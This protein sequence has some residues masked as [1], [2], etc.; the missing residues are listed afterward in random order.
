[1]YKCPSCDSVAVENYYTNQRQCVQCGYSGP[2]AEFSVEDDPV[3]HPSHYTFS[4]YE[5]IDVISAWDLNFNLG[6]VVKYIARCDHKDNK[7]QDLEKA[8]YYLRH[9][10]AKEELHMGDPSLSYGIAQVITEWGLNFNLGSV[11]QFV[12]ESTMCNAKEHIMVELRRAENSLT[13]EIEHLKQD[14]D[15]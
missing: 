5:V 7:I 3:A 8:L 12:V 14:N 10:M 13:R 11:I 1:M 9:E 15:E 4:K 2:T 6:N